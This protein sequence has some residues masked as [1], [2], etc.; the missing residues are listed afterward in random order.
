MLFE[1]DRDD[2]GVL[3]ELEL[4]EPAPLWMLALFGGA[5]LATMIG[6]PIAIWAIAGESSAFASEGPR[7]GDALRALV[8]ASVMW[9]LLFVAVRRV[10]SRRLRVSWDDWG[11]VEWDGF[12]V[13]T[14]IA[15]ERARAELGTRDARIA[16]AHV[17]DDDGRC[18]SM[19]TSEGAFPEWQPDRACTTRG[20]EPLAARLRSLPRGIAR[21]DARDRV[22]P[23]AWWMQ[24]RVVFPF[25]V[26]ASIGCACMP[27]AW[28]LFGIA[29]TAACVLT[30]L[31]AA[32]ELARLTRTSWGLR[33]LRPFVLARRE[34]RVLVAHDE[35]G[36][37]VRI[38]ARG[39]RA[40]DGSLVEKPRGRVFARLGAMPA[41]EGPYREG[42]VAR[43]VE[44]IETEFDRRLRRRRLVGASVE[45][46]ARLG[47]VGTSGVIAWV[48]LWWVAHVS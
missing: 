41:E 7:W 42:L 12:H 34:G 20:L 37:V 1:M 11:I 19:L 15:W 24:S 40:S 46:V 28:A 26:L 2:A 18:I 21:P 4:H 48:L 31:P 33:D 13:R 43:A 14:A 44:A 8:P 35:D 6:V 39:W 38:D 45:L 27:P 47:L 3:G 16:W 36:A 9:A 10:A 22:R 32:I 5:G 17:F 25:I 23:D 30:T 29:L